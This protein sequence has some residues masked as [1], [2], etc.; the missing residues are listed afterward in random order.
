[1][2]F[3][4]ADRRRILLLV[5]FQGRPN[6]CIDINLHSYIDGWKNRSIDRHGLALV[7]WPLEVDPDGEW[8]SAR[9][10]ETVLSLNVTAFSAESRELLDW[11]SAAEER[12]VVFFC[13]GALFQG[14]GGPPVLEQPVRHLPRLGRGFVRPPIC[15]TPPAI[16]SSYGGSVRGSKNRTCQTLVAQGVSAHLTGHILEA[17]LPQVELKE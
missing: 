4:S 13:K 17:L 11:G 1:M 14:K 8:I 3:K 7:S 9:T 10:E 2:P 5:Y 6:P 12:P 16:S 15:P